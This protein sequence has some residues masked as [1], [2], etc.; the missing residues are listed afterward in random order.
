M[1]S[2]RV[3]ATMLLLLACTSPAAARDI[4][5]VSNKANSVTSIILPD[6]VKICKGQ[7]SRWTDG[8]PVM[9]VM[10]D[11]SA[12]EM[13]VVLEKIYAMSKSEVDAAI[14]AANHGRVNHPAIVIVDSDDTLVERV[15][16][17]PGAI[18]LVDVYSITGGI[19]V[20]K[21]AGKLPL[22]PGYPLH[23]N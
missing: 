16:T 17:T 6:L 3:L 13:K 14:S 12:P 8:K 9:L 4:A 11:P 22:E 20:L 10:R 2:Q 5:L 23:G 18:G 15:E 19:T 21:V 1:F 7:T